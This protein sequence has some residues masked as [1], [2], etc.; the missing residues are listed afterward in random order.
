VVSMSPLVVGDLAGG[1]VFSDV[2]PRTKAQGLRYHKVPGCP[3][4]PSS[5]DRVF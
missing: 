2:P 3:P 4:G 1:L 5:G